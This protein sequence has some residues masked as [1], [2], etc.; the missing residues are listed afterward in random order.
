MEVEGYHDRSH[1]HSVRYPDLALAA[2]TGPDLA[3][4][5]ALPVAAACD[6]DNP[7]A[8]RTAV[9]DPHRSS[10][11]SQKAAR[12]TDSAVHTPAQ[13][14]RTPAVHTGLAVAGL[15]PGT[16]PVAA[17]MDTGGHSHYDTGRWFAV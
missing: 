15:D 9:M 14:E 16:H 7:A 6:F 12:H 3:L 5:S 8:G 13:A 10:D 11:H 2:R 17:Q 4:A 1:G